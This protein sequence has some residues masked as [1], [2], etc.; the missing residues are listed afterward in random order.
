MAASGW[1]SKSST[2]LTLAGW[3]H[4]GRHLGLDKAGSC[5]RQLSLP[6]E[7]SSE[8]CYLVET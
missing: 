2:L 1:I 4:F 3:G 7:L 8:A 6:C 5:P